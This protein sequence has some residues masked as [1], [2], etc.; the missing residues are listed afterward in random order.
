[1]VYFTAVFPYVTLAIL[2]V[3]GLTLPGAWH[4]VVYYLYPDPSRLADFQVRH[5]RY[6]QMSIATLAE[7]TTL[8]LCSSGVDGGL[9]SSPLLLWCCIRNRYHNEQLQ[10]SQE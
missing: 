5:Y 2:L 1:M 4:G 9:R 8:H 10:Q 6:T 7:L 3:R